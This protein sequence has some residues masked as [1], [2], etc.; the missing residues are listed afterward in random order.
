[1]WVIVCVNVCMFVYDVYFRVVFLCDSIL[2]CNQIM[3]SI[4]L[5]CQTLCVCLVNVFCVCTT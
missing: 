4:K 3:V 1:M 5:L 2:Q